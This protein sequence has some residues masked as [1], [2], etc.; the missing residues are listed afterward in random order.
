[1]KIVFAS[2]NVGS[3]YAAY[4]KKLQARL[5]PSSFAQVAST[6]SVPHPYPLSPANLKPVPASIL[7]PWENSVQKLVASCLP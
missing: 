3:I 5:R 1:V 6:P 4:N 2:N 7:S